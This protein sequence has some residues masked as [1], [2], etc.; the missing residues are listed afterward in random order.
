MIVARYPPTRVPGGMLVRTV[1]PRATP[2][3]Q[4]TAPLVRFAAEM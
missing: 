4:A 3:I 1:Q 2:G